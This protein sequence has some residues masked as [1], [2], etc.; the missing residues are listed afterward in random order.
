MPPADES[1]LPQCGRMGNAALDHAEPGH[2]V[3]RVHPDDPPYHPHHHHPLARAAY[4]GEAKDLSAAENCASSS[5][6]MSKLAATLWTS[7]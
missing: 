1:C 6:L 5:S 7:S 2:H 4:S 3:A